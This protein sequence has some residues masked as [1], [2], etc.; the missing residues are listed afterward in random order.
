MITIT[1]KDG[2][3]L[4]LVLNMKAI[5][6]NI[7]TSLALFIREGKKS[8][9]DP[10]I[11]EVRSSVGTL[12]AP[13]NYFIPHTWQC[14]TTVPLQ[15]S[16]FTFVFSY[17]DFCF[18]PLKTWTTEIGSPKWPKILQGV[19]EIGTKKEKNDWVHCCAEQRKNQIGKAKNP[20]TFMI[21]DKNIM[22]SHL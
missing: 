14:I 2:N 13:A 3:A 4:T 17:W 6:N 1:N 20:L 7:E 5:P 12:F 21:L 19:T 22:E 15:C 11:G 10:G 16:S 8:R 18:S 9:A